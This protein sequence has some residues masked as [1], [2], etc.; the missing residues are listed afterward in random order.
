MVSVALER[1]T[2]VLIT[3]VSFFVM[4]SL[5]VLVHEFG[6][7]VV[8]KRSGIKVEEFGLGYPPRLLTV[9]KH[10]DT[11]Y[12][13]NAIPFGGFV[14]MP[15]ED[16]PNTVG[17]FA[18]KPKLTRLS[19]LFAGPFMNFILATVVFTVSFVAGLPEPSTEVVT[20]V[21]VSKG[22]PAETG[23]L[24]PGDQIRSMNG[25]P[26]TM[27]SQFIQETAAKKGQQVSLGI[28]RK[29]Q[30]LS[31]SLVPR[32]NPPQGEGAIGLAMNGEV[33]A[34]TVKKLAPGEAFLRG[35]QQTASVVF[36]T[37]YAPVL[38]IRGTISPEAARPVGPIGIAR[39]TGDAAARAVNSGWWF[40]ILQLTAFIS[41][42]LG[43]TN[44]LP[45]PALDGGRIFFIIVETIR[46]KRIDPRK[47][48][49][50]HLVG[51]AILLM[52]MFLVTFQD[53]ISPLP[54]IQWPSPF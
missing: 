9:W 6:H 18:A 40:P 49:T 4:L 24:Q 28:E 25:Q 11:A 44:L 50:I 10:G 16:D 38:L 5:L 51:L 33:T 46:G 53:I 13:V 34:W 36:L 45:F 32:V 12:T 21:S 52:L 42:A 23:G 31:V 54:P 20:V 7:F 39:M 2:S 43:I 47:E 37:V 22:S 19:V 29:G 8:A 48:G 41:A 30:P 3:I 17:G 27:L 15:G 26:I 14:R 1:N 35:A